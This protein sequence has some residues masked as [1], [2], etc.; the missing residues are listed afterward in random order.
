MYYKDIPTMPQSAL[1]VIFLHVI[2]RKTSRSLS[3]SMPSS[4]I[5]PYTCS[6]IP[7]S[8]HSCRTV[9]ITDKSNPHIDTS[10]FLAGSLAIP[11]GRVGKNEC[12]NPTESLSIHNENNIHSQICTLDSIR[13]RFLLICFASSRKQSC[14]RCRRST[15]RRK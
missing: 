14:N 4:L 13:S 1:R 11:L 5:H 15:S 2:H 10:T 9:T 8:S 12:S 3:I 7:T 6:A